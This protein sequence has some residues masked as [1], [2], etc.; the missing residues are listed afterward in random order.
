MSKKKKKNKK[1][2]ASNKV[3]IKTD[4]NKNVNVKGNNTQA[5]KEVEP[6]KVDSSTNLENNKEAQVNKHEKEVETNIN[7]SEETKINVIIECDNTQANKE[8]E[9]NEADKATD[10]EKSY[11]KTQV[12]KTEKENESNRSDENKESSIKSNTSNNAINNFF[13]KHKYSIITTVAMISTAALSTLVCYNHYTSKLSKIYQD[14]IES[15]EANSKLSKLGEKLIKKDSLNP[16]LVYNIDVEYDYKFESFKDT[17]MDHFAITSSSMDNLQEVF[18]VQ[19]TDPN[20]VYKE[21]GKYKDTLISNKNKNNEQIVEDIKLDKVG[22]YVY[23]IA[24]KN[25]TKIEKSLLDEIK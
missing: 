24:A 4:T 5:N 20:L 3:H 23:F 9:L 2:N 22:N 1:N 16:D 21:F 13:K 10:L 6:K 19:S 12:N 11:D 17:I 18:V 14:N 15:A 8:V 7:A 25:S